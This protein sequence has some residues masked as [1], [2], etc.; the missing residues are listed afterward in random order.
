MEINV[1]DRVCVV[2]KTGSGK[3]V[4]VKKYCQQFP[5]VIFVD[6]K[7]EHKGQ[8]SD[9]TVS[10]CTEMQDVFKIMGQQQYFIHYQPF[11]LNKDTFNEF[12]KHV[13]TKGN[14]TLVLDEVYYLCFPQA[15]DYHQ[16]IIRMGR[17]KGVG[18]WHLIQRPSYVDNY[19][20]SEA[21]HFFIFKLQLPADKQKMEGVIG[22]E[23][24]D[25][26]KTLESHEFF[27]YNPQEGFKHFNPITQ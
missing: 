13:F 1:N 27:Y 26:M 25:R 21:E 15:V 11:E 17:S 3:S 20:I 5:R 14:V 7:H 2:G 24:Q 16:K 4:L 6:P 9:R 12:C 22:E 18:I 19:I 8:F 10:F 23:L